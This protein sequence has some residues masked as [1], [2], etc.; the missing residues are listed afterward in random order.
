MVLVCIVRLVRLLK[1]GKVLGC[2]IVN[3]MFSMMSLSIVGR[4]F[5]L[6]FCRWLRYLC[7][8]FCRVV[9]C[10]LFEK[11]ELVRLGFGFLLDV[12]VVVMVVFCEVRL[13]WW[14]LW[15]RC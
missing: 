3:T 7:L 1:D 15:V 12:V 10:W 13:I 14:W 8:V 5:M 2:S 6:L 4:V 11:F 9:V